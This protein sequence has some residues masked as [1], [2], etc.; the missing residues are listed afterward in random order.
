MLCAPQKC[1]AARTA[2]RVSR[3]VT[4]PQ[5]TKIKVRLLNGSRTR[6][7]KFKPSAASGLENLS[8]LPQDVELAQPQPVTL[9][10]G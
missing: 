7:H 4:K 10:R 6:L 9:R 8:V 3:P 5:G 1:E 2:P